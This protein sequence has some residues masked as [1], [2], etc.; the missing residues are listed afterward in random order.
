MDPVR[1]RPA[2]GTATTASGRSASNGV[3]NFIVVKYK[4]YAIIRLIFMKKITFFLIILTFSF[5]SVF[6]Q[7]S[8][9]QLNSTT[10]STATSTKQSKIEQRNEKIRSFASQMQQRLNIIVGNLE[11]T[12]FRIETQINK[13]AS[14]TATSTDISAVRIKLADAK[15]K[16]EELK[17]DIAGLGQKVEEV[18]VSKK[19]K[20]AFY[21]VREKLI[22][23]FVA[24]IK[25]IHKELLDS[26][27]LV[28]KEIIKLNKQENS[29]S[30]ENS[31]ASTT[32]TSTNQ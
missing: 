30:T 2:K 23:S 7:T 5:S 27:K 20:T 28:K 31:T 1:S 16:I 25:V 21:T 14:S 10:T 15:K 17:T 4:V 6:A 9:S 22:K 32:A 3:D 24:K 18:I 19:P 26:V 11:K 12:A 8:T 29:I 13:L